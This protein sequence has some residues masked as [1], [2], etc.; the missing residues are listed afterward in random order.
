M[1]SCG[2]QP[3]PQQVNLGQGNKHRIMIF[4]PEYNFYLFLKTFIEHHYYLKISDNEESL[5]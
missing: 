2:L 1:F 4:S 3:R 5:S